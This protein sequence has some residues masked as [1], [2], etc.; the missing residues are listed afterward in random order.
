MDEGTIGGNMITPVVYPLPLVQGADLDF[1]FTWKIDGV[2][3]DLSLYTAEAQVRN[4]INGENKILDLSS[5]GSTII[6]GGA[7]GKITLVAIAAV[8]NLITGLETGDG[9]WDIELTLISSG[10]VT[11]LMGGPVDFIRQVTK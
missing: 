10:H 5:A 9:V 7:T 3:V 11:N 2:A 4:G 8:T 6:L 1:S